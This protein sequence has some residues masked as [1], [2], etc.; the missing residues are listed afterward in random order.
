MFKRKNL[1]QVFKVT[2]KEDSCVYTAYQDITNN[3]AMLLVPIN[4]SI[5]TIGQVVFG[6]LD[7]SSKKQ[8]MIRLFNELND[9]YNATKFYIDESNH[10]IAEIIYFCDKDAFNADLF[11]DIFIRTFVIIQSEGHAKVMEVLSS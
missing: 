3:L 11:F 10:L 5:H 4:N 2:A 6:S 8:R 7:D 1:L 9:K